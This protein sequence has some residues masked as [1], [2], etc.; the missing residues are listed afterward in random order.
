MV[1][2]IWGRIDASIRHQLAIADIKRIDF[3]DA[4]HMLD[5][6]RSQPIAAQFSYFTAGA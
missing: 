5:L 6:E 4:G 1:A 3:V 2:V